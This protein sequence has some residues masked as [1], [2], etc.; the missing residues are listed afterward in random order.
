MLNLLLVF[1]LLQDRPVEASVEAFIKGDKAARGELVVAGPYAILPLQN[2][3]EKSPEKVDL[4]IHELKMAAAWPTPGDFEGKYK[5]DGV[6]ST[7]DKREVTHSGLHDFVEWGGFSLYLDHF[8][9]A[10]LKAATVSLKEIRSSLQAVREICRQTGLDYGYF[11]NHIVLALPERLWPSGPPPALPTLAADDLKKAKGL[12]ERLKDKAAEK[13]DEAAREL[14]KMGPG[15]IPFLASQL[16]RKE[17]DIAVRCSEL[18]VRLRPRAGAYGPAG[19]ARQNLDSAGMEVFRRACQ[20]FPDK[21][22]R[23][24]KNR[25]LQGVADW[26][27]KDHS[28]KLDIRGGHAE[29]TVSIVIS[30]RVI[31]FLSLMTQRLDLDFALQGDVIVVDSPEAIEKLVSEGK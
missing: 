28:L 10:R 30:G 8:D 6:S 3:R 26:L 14:F 7:D 27:K 29:R 9:P 24:F 23:E 22:H 11:H 20:R 13:R 4:L 5:Y 17:P 2:A 31:D 16:G 12:V 19:A 1:L 15:V 18:I 21:G 25:V